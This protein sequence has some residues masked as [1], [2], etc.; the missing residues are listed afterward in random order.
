VTTPPDAGAPAPFLGGD[1]RTVIVALDHALVSGQIEGLT[2]PADVLREVARAEPDG[3]IVPMGMGRLARTAAPDV[4]WLLTADVYA[5]STLPGRSGRDD[6]HATVWSAADAARAGAAGLKVL[7]V[8]GRRDADAFEREL[9]DVARLVAEAR[10]VGLPVM[11]ETVLWGPGVAAGDDDDA[12]M[13]V[14]A[15]R[16]GFELGA[17]L[18]KIAVPDDLGPLRELTSGLP[19]PIVLM[20]GPASDPAATFAGLGAALEAGAAGVALGRNVWTYPAPAA[21]VE[22]L[23]RLVHG[24][25]APERA[26]A[27]LAGS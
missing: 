15:A 8:F 16:T 11:I 7:L 25:Q 2:R 13:V 3:F 1:G 12:T 22:A 24:R 18:L 10:D 21:Y 6:V 20:G 4:P 5:T 27:G 23:H 26:L 19:V 14:N 17:D 9:R